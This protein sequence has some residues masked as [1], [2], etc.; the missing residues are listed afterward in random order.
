VQHDWI[1][2]L[3]VHGTMGT[4]DAMCDAETLDFL[5]RTGERS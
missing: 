4:V 5:R 2:S 3:F 1:G